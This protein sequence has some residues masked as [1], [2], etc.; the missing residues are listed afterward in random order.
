MFKDKYKKEMDNIKPSDECIDEV[1][2]YNPT[3]KRFNSKRIV[4][5]AVIS[6]LIFSLV[7]SVVISAFNTNITEDRNY[8]NSE[9]EIVLNGI[10][11]AESYDEIKAIIN[12]NF[13]LEDFGNGDVNIAPDTTVDVEEDNATTGE[14]DHSD[15][16]NQVD[17]VQESDIIKNDGKYIYYYS[18]TN[19]KLYITK[20]E[21][22]KMYQSSVIDMSETSVISMFLLKNKLA[23]IGYKNNGSN[24]TS[25]QELFFGK[26]HCDY[27]DITDKSNPVLTAST[28]QDGNYKDSRVVGSIVY[29]VTN[30]WAFDEENLIPKCNGVRIDVNRIYIPNKI[31]SNSFT[32]ITAF[33]SKTQSDNFKSVISIMCGAS[34]IYSGK[35]N[36]YIMNRTYEDIKN[37]EIDTLSNTVIYK[38]NINDGK[39]SLLARGMVHGTVEDQFCIDESENTLRIA[40][41]IRFLTNKNGTTSFEPE[42]TASRIYCLNEKLEVIGKSEDIGISERL[43]SVRYIGNIAYAVTFRQTDP[44]Y[45]IDLSN[46][47]SPKILSE[48]KIDGFSTY[49]HPYGDNYLIGIG[50]DADP[51]TGVSTGL[52]VT[53]FDISNPA[54]VFDVSSY[55]IKWYDGDN[56]GHYNTEAAYNHKALLIDYKKGIIAIPLTKTTYVSETIFEEPYTYEEWKNHTKT[57]FAFLSFDGNT[58]TEKATIDISEYTEDYYHS[59]HKIRALYIGNYGYVIDNERIIS[60]SLETINV[61]STFLF[62]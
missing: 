27:Y 4:F 51:E 10:R 44:L 52:K 58:L 2:L 25:D 32:V 54:D 14:P 53:L 1:L 62:E 40:T 31:N 61:V 56:S 59:N 46:P 5:V 33:D 8:D 21:N 49:M 38:I 48:L 23:V 28:S 30:H 29:I 13:I 41:Y 55:I 50:Y 36:L 9:P 39:L 7:C 22:G 3:P 26:T 17:G 37:S 12:N 20:T 42:N 15:T 11:K 43:K 60:I 16:N 18:R 35:E 57:S 24:K 6:I 45:A 47:K 34:H 19:D